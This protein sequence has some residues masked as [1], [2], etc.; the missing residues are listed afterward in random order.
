MGVSVTA[1]SNNQVFGKRKE[2]HIVILASGDRIR[3][4]TIRPWMVALS[5]CFLGTM[6][7]GYLGA[8]TYLVL[9]DN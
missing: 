3:H 9:R 5:I 8:T 4:M 6:A 7:I 2:Q 1:G